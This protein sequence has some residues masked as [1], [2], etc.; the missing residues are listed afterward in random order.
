MTLQMVF[1]FRPKSRRVSSSTP[2][3]AR[4]RG[5]ERDDIDSQASD[6]AFVEETLIRAVRDIPVPRC[7]DAGF[8]LRP[9]QRANVLNPA[10]RHRSIVLA[11]AQAFA[12]TTTDPGA[13]LPPWTLQSNPRRCV[14]Y[15]DGARRFAGHRFNIFHTHLRL[16][17]EAKI[18]SRKQK[19]NVQNDAVL[20]PKSSACAIPMTARASPRIGTAAIG[21]PLKILTSPPDRFW[22]QG[23]ATAAVLTKVLNPALR[24]RSIVLAAAQAFAFT[25]TDPGATT[26]PWTLQSNP[27]RCVFYTDGPA[28][29]G[30]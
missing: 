4:D 6:N 3:E 20:L 28:T 12:L 16:H 25:T 26:P 9:L 18:R 17:I 14:F 23:L 21:R 10:L 7:A 30:D 27:R 19:R 15:T 5:L 24:H 2:L 8:W 22:G 11:A 13:S 29:C 1:G